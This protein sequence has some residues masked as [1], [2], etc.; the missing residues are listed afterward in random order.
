[1]VNLASTSACDFT[2]GRYFSVPGVES[3]L[4]QLALFVSI[5]PY[6]E[7]YGRYK[8][9]GAKQAVRV[10]DRWAMAGIGDHGTFRNNGH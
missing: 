1:M 5:M 6:N 2:R 10:L 3:S 8:E 9:F 4:K 7:H